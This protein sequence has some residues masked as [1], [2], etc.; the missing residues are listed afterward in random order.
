MF[1][2]FFISKVS[3]KWGAY[4]CPPTGD[5]TLHRRRSASVALNMYLHNISKKKV[6]K[7]FCERYLQLV[8]LDC[9]NV[10][11]LL[12]DTPEHSSFSYPW[13]EHQFSRCKPATWRVWPCVLMIPMAK[14]TFSGNWRCW[15]VNSGAEGIIRIW[16][17]RAVPSLAYPVKLMALTTFCLNALTMGLVLLKS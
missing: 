16:G 9:I 17:K 14:A 6:V 11:C 10:K 1:W 7:L 3:V 2:N 13:E 5:L 12:D 15:N 4:Q 8:L